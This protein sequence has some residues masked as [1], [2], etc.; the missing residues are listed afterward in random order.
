MFDKTGTLTL[1]K[2]RVVHVASALVAAPAP[3]SGPSPSPS[4]SNQ[5]PLLE[6]PQEGTE[7]PATSSDAFPTLLHRLLVLLL[8]AES[9]S[10]HPIANAIGQYA[11]QVILILL[12]KLLNQRT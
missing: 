9:N 7:A 8:L 11:K 4:P 5:T 6:L 1:G 10:D 2:P 3:S 12:N